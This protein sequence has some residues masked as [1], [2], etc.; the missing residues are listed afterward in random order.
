MKKMLW[1]ISAILLG[2]GSLQVHA[3]HDSSPG[4]TENRPKSFLSRLREAFLPG[5]SKSSSAVPGN[6]IAPRSRHDHESHVLYLNGGRRS[7]PDKRPS[8]SDV[9]PANNLLHFRF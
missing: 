3:Q 7:L 9:E 4:L 6:A 5:F 8:L 2:I 1:A